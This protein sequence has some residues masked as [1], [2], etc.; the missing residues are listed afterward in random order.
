MEYHQEVLINGDVER[1]FPL[2]RRIRLG[3][4]NFEIG[5]KL[6]EISI[7]NHDISLE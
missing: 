7:Q 6:A 4:T 2:L 5:K 1:V 3:G